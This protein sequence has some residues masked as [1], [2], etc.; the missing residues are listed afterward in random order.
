[1]FSGDVDAQIEA[2]RMTGA[3]PDG[4]DVE[5]LARDLSASSA[6][7]PMQMLT[8]GEGA[9]VAGLKEAVRLL[10]RHRLRPPLEVTLFVRN[11]FAL[12]AF[13]KSLGGNVTLMSALM[14][15]VQRL[16]QLNAELG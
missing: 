16:P 13:V 15:L 5:A 6:L 2:M 4:V 3:V 11:V 1:V 12:N 8:G 14:P 7:Q 10:L 9:I